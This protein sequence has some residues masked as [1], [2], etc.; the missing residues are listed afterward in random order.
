[1]FW[2]SFQA[3]EIFLFREKLHWNWKVRFIEIHLKRRR[4]GNLISYALILTLAC[5]A[6]EDLLRGSMSSPQVDLNCDKLANQSWLL[7]EKK[8]SINCSI[9]DR[10]WERQ[11]QRDRERKAERQKNSLQDFKMPL[12]EKQT[13]QSSWI[14]PLPLMTTEENSTSQSPVFSPP[15]LKRFFVV[16][17]SS[18]K[19]L[20]FSTESFAY[21]LSQQHPAICSDE[22][23]MNSTRRLRQS[24][25]GSK[26]Y[27]SFKTQRVY[28]TIQ[29]ATSRKY[30]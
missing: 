29:R 7:L 14:Q 19:Y 3:K 26:F 28:R 16:Q 9:Q 6:N 17:L 13:Y 22:R 15:K 20:L 23:L 4:R 12:L 8:P 24:Y 5:V 2:N 18:N 11:R 30:M 25:I 21:F 27:I 1:M 10:D